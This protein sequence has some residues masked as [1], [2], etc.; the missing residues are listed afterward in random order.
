MIT[1]NFLS[2]SI[3]YNYI[4]RR[5]LILLNRNTK[6]IDLAILQNQKVQGVKRKKSVSLL[7]PVGHDGMATKGKIL[8][9]ST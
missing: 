4:E 7:N 8:G 5:N 1:H 6:R 2:V 9:H 3:R